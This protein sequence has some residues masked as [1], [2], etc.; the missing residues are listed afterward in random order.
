MERTLLK[1]QQLR[2]VRITPRPLRE[3][4]H[5]LPVIPHFLRR[6]IKSLNS[7][8]LIRPVNK[9]SPRQR[10]KPTQDRNLSQRLLGRDTAVWREHGAQQE[11][12]EFGLVVSDEHGWSG[13]EVLGAL[14]YVE[15]HAG[16]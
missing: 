3:D 11:H 9:H 13:G 16:R 1:R 4:K 12:V 7:R 6:T 10:H 5:T 2:P 8:L 14:D 15:S